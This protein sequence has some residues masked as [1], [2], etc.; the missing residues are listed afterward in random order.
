MRKRNGYVIACA[1]PE[2]R[3]KQ[4]GSW[5]DKLMDHLGF[6][7]DGYYQVGHA[8]LILIDKDTSHCEF[9]D[10]GRY[11]APK[12]YGRV[13]NLKHDHELTIHTKAVFQNG[14]L[15]NTKAI[16]EELF[17][18]K[19]GH[20]AGPLFGSHTEINYHKTKSKIKSM[21]EKEFIDYGP[22]VQS[23][24]N[25]SRFVNTAIRAGKPKRDEHALLKFPLTISPTPMW[26]LRALQNDTI[27]VGQAEPLHES[28]KVYLREQTS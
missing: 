27:C 11:H 17:S 19:S 26:N 6:S 5:Y 8:A 2:T 15:I 23:G 1:W 3:C 24:T 16:L 4:A 14:V 7:R 18:N 13:R 20:G 22:F 21:I 12:G 10:F 25:C 28:N 9:Y